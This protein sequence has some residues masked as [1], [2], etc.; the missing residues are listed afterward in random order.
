MRPHARTAAC[1]LSVALLFSATAGRAQESGAKGG[2]T[3]SAAGA[4]V[5]FVDVKDGAVV[6]TKLTVH[7]GLRGMGVA[8]AGTAK[9]NSGHHHVLIDTDLPPL[10][11]PIPNDANHLHFGAGQ[12]EATIDLAPGEHTLQLLL[13]DAKHVPHSPPIVSDRIKVT[14]KEDAPSGDKA[15]AQGRHPSAAGA[16]VYIVGLGN[17]SYLPPNAQIRFGL[18]NMGV[19]PAGFSKP[20]TGHHHLLIDSDLPPLDKPIPNDANHLHFGAGQTEAK[21]QLPLGRHK[22]QLLLADENHVVHDPPVASQPIFVFVTPSG[23][24]PRP[25]V[26]RRRF[27]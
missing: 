18:V 5:Y 13:A 12:T 27:F 10:D 9:E 4:A 11:K 25:R 2:P 23:L 14:A 15:G 16:R 21:V 6:P 24:P 19:A 1:L 26:F 8:P 22:L 3:P 17:G 20:N 7:F